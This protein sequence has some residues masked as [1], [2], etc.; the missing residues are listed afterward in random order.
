MTEQTKDVYTW[1]VTY[2]DGT[3]TDEFDESRPDGR[4]FAEREDKPV[5]TITLARGEVEVQSM[6]IPEGAES[7][8]FRR[9]FILFDPNTNEQTLR[10]TVHCI[11]WKRGEEASYLFVYNDGTTFL[12][13]DLQAV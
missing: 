7:V 13:D 12:T 6:S 2:Q 1:R 11:G 5:Q 9:R 3:A 8:F 10:H 4:G